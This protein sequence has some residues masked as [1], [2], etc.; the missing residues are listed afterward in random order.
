MEISP[1]NNNINSIKNRD[2]R[3][4]KAGVAAMTILS[5]GTALAH[6]SKNRDFL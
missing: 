5:T 6:I 2:D 3:K 4:I 1:V